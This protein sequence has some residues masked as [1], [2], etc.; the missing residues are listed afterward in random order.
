MKYWLANLTALFIVITITCSCSST[1]RD[2]KAYI[3]HYKVGKPYE[4]NKIRSTPK[5]VSTYNKTGLAS[6]YGP[7]FHGKKTANG[8]IFN[9]RELT[10]AHR[11]LPLPSLVRVTNLHNNKTIVLRVNDRGPFARDK[12]NRIIDV[13]ERAAEILG[14]KHRGIAKVRVKFLPNATASLHERL[15]IKK[16]KYLYAS[17]NHSIS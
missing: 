5:E 12:K 15:R 7:R 8:E 3:G 4:I 9:Q 16:H 14:L 13:S 2:S 10:A 17:K 11:T 1:S 6:W